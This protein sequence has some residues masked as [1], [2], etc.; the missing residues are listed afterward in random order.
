METIKASEMDLGVVREITQTTIDAVYPKYYPQGAVAFFKHHHNDENILADIR[1]DIVYLLRD[2]GE[3]VGTVT[4]KGNDINRLF[5]LPNCQH[6]GYGRFLLDF[7]ENE[8]RKNFDEIMLD[9][10][11]PAKRIYLK[12]GYREVEYNQIE[13]PNGDFLCF[14]LMRKTFEA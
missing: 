10:S 13:T 9:A 14:D 12:R 2:E 1:A 4:V 3:L 8:I 6:K 11:L 7:A 5:V